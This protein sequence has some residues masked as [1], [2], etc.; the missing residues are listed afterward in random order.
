[1]EPGVGVGTFAEGFVGQCGICGVLS[2]NSAD[3]PF[4]PTSLAVWITWIIDF[5]SWQTEQ[6]LCLD[7]H[8]FKVFSTSLFFLIWNGMEGE[9]KTNK[10]Y[11]KKLSGQG[12]KSCVRQDLPSELIQDSHFRHL[13]EKWW[14]AKWEEQ[15][16]G[17]MLCLKDLFVLCV[18]H[19]HRV[20]NVKV[21]DTPSLLLV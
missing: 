11:K 15:S 18:T 1:M 14:D 8:A 19:K 9:A 5:P 3:N 6:I 16:C 12:I 20:Q 13:W 10:T 2:G 17:R 4:L 21:I 7:W